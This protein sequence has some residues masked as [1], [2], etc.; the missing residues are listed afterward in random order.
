MYI[1]MRFPFPVFFIPLCRSIVPSVTIS[2]FVKDVLWF[3]FFDSV[4]LLVMNFFHLLYIW[5]YLYL[6]FTSER[7][8]PGNRILGWQHLKNVVLLV[9]C[10]HILTRNLYSFLYSILCLFTLASFKKISSPQILSYSPG[11]PPSHLSGPRK[12][13][14]YYLSLWICLF[15]HFI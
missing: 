8:F 14:M 13:L 10:L 12:P 4:G 6:A 1:Y 3:F 15:W 9:Y 7:C 5:K 2:F 11:T